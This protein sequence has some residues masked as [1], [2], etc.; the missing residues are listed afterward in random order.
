MSEKGLELKLVQELAETGRA[1]QG[2]YVLL[3]DDRPDCTPP[4][5]SDIPMIDLRRLLQCD[6]ESEK[7]R[8][9]VQSWGIFQVIG[10]ELSRSFV[11]EL[12]DVTRTFFKLPVEEKQKHSNLKS[13]EFDFEGYGNDLVA[14]EDQIL[15]W[16]D[17]L[18]LLVQPEDKR[19]LDYWPENPSSFREMLHE[20]AMKTRKITEIVLIALA[21]ILKLDENCFKD[22]VDDRAEVFARFN[23]YPSCLRPELVH[24]VKPHSDGSVITI[25]LPDKEV[26]GLQVLQ[27]ADWVK[28][29]IIR[30]ALVINMGNQMEVMSNG[31][32]KSSVHRV[33]TGSKERISIAMFFS[34]QPEKM[35]E[36]AQGLV[37]EI[38]P[39]L[40]RKMKAN[41]FLKAFFD[42]FA[43]GETT[44]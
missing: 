23:Y 4:M 14:S 11:D 2:R 27:D 1:P 32:F 3:E 26:E 19:K 18:Y 15:D 5:A 29:P 8:Y 35:L 6:D 13:G 37:S 38:R 12:Q 31:I 25:L 39:C 30:D 21:K 33:V 36:P 16:N 40:Y 44:I 43:Q 20:Y 9:A 34:L 28:I 22:Q 10:H 17:R 42:K 7:L 24:G 41:D